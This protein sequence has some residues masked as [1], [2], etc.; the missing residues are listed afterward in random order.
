MLLALQPY[1]LRIGREADSCDRN[2]WLFLLRLLNRVL[3]EH[4]FIKL[5]IFIL[6]RILPKVIRQDCIRIFRITLDIVTRIDKVEVILG[7]VRL[8]DFVPEALV[9]HNICKV[10]RIVTACDKATIHQLQRL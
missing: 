1:G 7:L 5:W 9:I 2:N 3:E 10:R 8:C 4:Q 6:Q